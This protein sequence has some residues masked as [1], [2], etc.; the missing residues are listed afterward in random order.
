MQAANMVAA[1]F[2]ATGQDAAHVVEAAQVETILEIQN[3]NL[4]A[5]AVV[6]NVNVGVVGGG[7]YLPAFKQ[8]RQLILNKELSPSELAGAV[9]IAVLAGELSGLAALSSHT[10]A[11]AHCQLA[12]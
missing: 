5:A 1:M 6:P 12:R 9:G 11:Q 4:Y 7:T 10:L 8:A 2:L 3:K